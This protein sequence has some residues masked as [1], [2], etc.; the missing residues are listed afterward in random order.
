MKTI[1]DKKESK[2]EKRLAIG[3]IIS[4]GLGAGMMYIGNEATGNLTN[5]VSQH[6]Y[7]MIWGTLATVGPY[8][9]SKIRDLFNKHKKEN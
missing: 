1:N 7:G 8:A 4:L 5:N 2:L 3:V 6:G 9:Y